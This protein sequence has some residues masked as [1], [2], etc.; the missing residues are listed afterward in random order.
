MD[1]DSLLTLYGYSA[2]ANRLVL[3][4]AA[5]LSAEDFTRECSPS[6]GSIRGLVLHMLETQAFFLARCGGYS[7]EDIFDPDHFPTATKIQDYWDNLEH[8]TCAFLTRLCDVDLERE[9]VPFQRFPTMHFPM[10]QLL[11]QAFHHMTQHRG[12][13]SILLTELGHPLPNLDIIVYFAQQSGQPW[14]WDNV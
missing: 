11:Y 14:P 7:F 4:T 1:R 13:L 12:E 6:H 2:Y 3:H 5:E 9:L 10:W 8:E